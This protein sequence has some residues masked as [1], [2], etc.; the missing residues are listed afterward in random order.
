MRRI[1][2]GGPLAPSRQTLHHLHRAHLLAIPFENLDVQLRH[3]RP[4]TI[5]AVYEKIVEERRGG[6]CYEMNGLFG[7]ALRELGFKVDYIAGAVNRQK[8]G[9]AALMNHL[10]LIV[11]LERP[12]LADVGFGNGLSSPMP[13]EEGSHRDGR[14][15][16]KLT[17]D[18]DWWRFYND[19][20]SG[21][22]FD[23]TEAPHEYAQFEHKARLMASTAESTF[24]QNLVAMKL[25]EDGKVELINTMFR[26]QDENGIS[27]ETAPNAGALACILREHF[28]LESPR[29]E[30]LWQRAA[31]QHKTWLR[32]RIRGF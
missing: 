8:N 27:E 23:F 6:W 22:T 17:K 16:F 13:L 18:G 1:N 12:Y 11:H 19:R 15:E 3:K 14:F 4:F 20:E 32:K 7:W 5:D 30:A 2:Y 21:S 9:D 26:R 24:V 31:A 25:L 28:A 29:V 10:A